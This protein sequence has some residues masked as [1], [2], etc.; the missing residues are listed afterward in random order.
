MYQ[1]C[2]GDII[3]WVGRAS[4]AQLVHTGWQPAPG[5]FCARFRHHRLVQ[6]LMQKL[7]L[8]TRNWE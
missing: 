2:L 7:L 3:C 5:I 8:N 1:E 4:G 6:L